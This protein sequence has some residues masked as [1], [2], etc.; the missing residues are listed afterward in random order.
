MSIKIY[1]IKIFIYIFIYYYYISDILYFE[2]VFLF[3]VAI[4]K[5][6]E[7][8]TSNVIISESLVL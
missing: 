4:I 3:K 2:I 5:Y 1:I 8:N 6:I 7:K